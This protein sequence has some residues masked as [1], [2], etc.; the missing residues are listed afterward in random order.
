MIC[1]FHYY[2]S[3]CWF[4]LLCYYLLSVEKNFRLP[5]FL[6]YDYFPFNCYII[7]LHMTHYTCKSFTSHH[8]LI[9]I[10]KNCFYLSI[11]FDVISNRLFSSLTYCWHSV[12][13]IGCS[14][15]WSIHLFLIYS[16]EKDQG[17]SI[18]KISWHINLN[19]IASSVKTNLLSW[20]NIF[21]I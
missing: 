18:V 10:V 16:L 4:P 9:L 5:Q 15:V 12:I 7:D 3:V 8:L 11:I 13:S 6:H 17:K 14:G 1:H 20:F 19:K 2:R 21:L